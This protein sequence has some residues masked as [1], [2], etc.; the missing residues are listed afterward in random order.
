MPKF[1]FKKDIGVPEEGN[2]SSFINIERHEFGS[3]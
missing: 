3:T 1:V 2:G